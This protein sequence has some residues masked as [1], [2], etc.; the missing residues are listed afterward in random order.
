MTESKYI[1]KRKLSTCVE[2]IWYNDGYEPLSRKERVLPAGSSQLIINLGNDR[3]R[4]YEGS[5]QHPKEYDPV[6]VAGV[7]T[8]HIFLDSHT[9]ISTINCG[10]ETGCNLFPVRYPCR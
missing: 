8:G 3:F 5:D 2:F 1:P 9:R 7:H 4:H 10:V 6:I